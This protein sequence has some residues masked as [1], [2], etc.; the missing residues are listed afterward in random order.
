M[1][2]PGD[3]DR[4]QAGFKEYYDLPQT[5]TIFTYGVSTEMIGRI[6]QVMVPYSPVI[7]AS[8]PHPNTSKLFIDYIRSLPGTN[9][10]AETGISLV[11]GRPG[12]KV[13]EKERKFMPPSEKIKVIAMDWDKDTSSENLKAARE[14]AKKVGVGY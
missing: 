8:A 5:K 10:I 9:R 4:I 2:E 13:P 11:Y 12:V 1:I 14:W 7:F 6:D 3:A